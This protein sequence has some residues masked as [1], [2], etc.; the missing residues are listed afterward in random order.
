MCKSRNLRPEQLGKIN[1]QVQS[2]GRNKTY[3]CTMSVQ[4]SD[5]KASSAVYVAERS[6][7]IAP[8]LQRRR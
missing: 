1:H 5:H 7:S 6:E 2:S 4:S 8:T 3:A